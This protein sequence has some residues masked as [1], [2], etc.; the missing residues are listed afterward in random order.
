MRS[1]GFSRWSAF[2]VGRLGGGLHLVGFLFFGGDRR[3]YKISYWLLLARFGYFYFKYI[4]G[5]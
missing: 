1:R 4:M 5:L 2:G 3:V